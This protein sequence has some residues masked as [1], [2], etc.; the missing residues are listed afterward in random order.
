MTF[1]L[2]MSIGDATD[3]SPQVQTLVSYHLLSGLIALIFASLVHAIV[4]TYFMGTGRWMEETT[5]VYKLN[6]AAFQE[7]KKLKY[8]A[9]LAMM[10]CFAMLIATG[11]FGAATDPAS[12]VDFRGWGGVSGGAIHM[13]IALLTWGL[14]CVV[15][16]YE[17]YTL[18]RNGELVETVLA[19]VKRIRLERGMSV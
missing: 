12:P 16:L 8:R 9:I 13:T 3:R 11:A 6:W 4:L 14:N 18:N 17:Y 15:N 5:T 19:D 10:A 2:G 7:S 1:S